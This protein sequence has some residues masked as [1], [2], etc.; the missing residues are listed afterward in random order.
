LSDIFFDCMNAAEAAGIPHAR[1]FDS[2]PLARCAPEF[3]ER[4]KPI[5]Q[6]F[7]DGKISGERAA[8]DMME[9]AEKHRSPAV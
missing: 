1:L 5:L 4:A 2:P 8:A 7:R 9:M 6:Q 3:V